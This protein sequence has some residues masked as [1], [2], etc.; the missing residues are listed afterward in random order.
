MP[1]ALWLPD[2]LVDFGVTVVTHDGWEGRGSADFDPRVVIAHHTA[3]RGSGVKVC[4]G[5]RPDLPGPLC[6]VVLAR[7][8]V[9]HVIAAGRA[10]HAGAGGWAGYSGNRRALGIEADN[11]GREPWPA[12]QIDAFHLTAAALLAGIN[13]DPSHLCFHREWAP[14]RKVDPHTLDPTEFR[15]ATGL[16]LQWWRTKQE[17]DMFTPEDR[18]RLKRIEQKQVE[19]DNTLAG[20]ATTDG[21]RSKDVRSLIGRIGDAL[22]VKR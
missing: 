6:Q 15:A 4:I 21:K 12:R 9:A 14:G 1:R 10:N 7:D 17:D 19:F 13:A 18:E 11:D 22:K 3:V 16:D 20:W 2:L 5:G 8:G